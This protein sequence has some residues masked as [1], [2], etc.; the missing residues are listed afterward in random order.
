MDAYRLAFEEQLAKNRK[1]SI[2]LSQIATLSSRTAK[3][4]AALKWLVQVLN[5]GM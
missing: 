4:K 3:A 2:Q 5:D 1:M